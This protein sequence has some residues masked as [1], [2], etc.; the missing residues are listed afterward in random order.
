M[1]KTLLDEALDGWRYAREGV[2]AELE[3]IPAESFGFQPVPSVRTVAELARHVV[4]SSEVMVGELTRPD[5]DF[6][7][8]SYPDHLKEHA[9]GLDSRQDKDAL[10]AL[11]RGTLEKGVARFRDAGELLML[12]R[13]TQFNGEPAT[14]LSWMSHGVAHEEYHRGQ[15]CVYARQLGLVPALTKLI[16][17][18]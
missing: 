9:G 1:A 16:H 8:Q 15:L 7:R 3:N 18:S 10:L 17:G 2:V 13:I 5:G 12:Q 4:E 14:R 11:L 6:T